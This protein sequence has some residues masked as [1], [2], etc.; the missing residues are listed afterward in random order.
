MIRYAV[1][2]DADHLIAKYGDCNPVDFALQAAEGQF[3][4]TLNI[5]GEVRDETHVYDPQSNSVIPR[6]A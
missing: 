4:I 2:N 6:N 5:D 3:V 1:I